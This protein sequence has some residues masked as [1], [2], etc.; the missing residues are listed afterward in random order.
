MQTTCGV[1]SL[2]FQLLTMIEIHVSK[3]DHYTNGKGIII[4]IELLQF[5][6][7]K[8]AFYSFTTYV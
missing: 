7:F 5:F 2:C 3:T 6:S 8:S 1:Y 4:F